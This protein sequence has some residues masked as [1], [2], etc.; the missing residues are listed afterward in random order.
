M[1]RLSGFLTPPEGCFCL[2]L[3]AQWLFAGGCWFGALRYGQLE[4]G[5]CLLVYPAGGVGLGEFGLLFVQ[6]T[7][8]GSLDAWSA[9]WSIGSSISLVHVVVVPG[10]P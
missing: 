6:W 9:A 5:V 2:G 10:F 1:R 8:S 4:R 3:P 7:I